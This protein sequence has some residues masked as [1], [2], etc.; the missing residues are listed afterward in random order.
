[1]LLLTRWA[2]SIRICVAIFL[3]MHPLEFS[4]DLPVHFYLN[5]V[6]HDGKLYNVH[7]IK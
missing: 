6:S 7:D 4:P 5:D 1:M 3:T 2:A